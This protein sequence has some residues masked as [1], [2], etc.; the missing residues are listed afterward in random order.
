MFAVCDVGSDDD[1]DFDVL[2]L[3]LILGQTN[4]RLTIAA[5]WISCLDAAVE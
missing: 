5:Y 1:K 2:R 3:L 4:N